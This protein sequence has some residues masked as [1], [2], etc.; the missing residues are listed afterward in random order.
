MRP[1]DQKTIAIEKI[2]FILTGPQRRDYSKPC[3]STWGSP[4]VSQEAEGE[5]GT[6]SKNIP[7]GFFKKEQR[8]QGKQA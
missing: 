3:R 6:M 2:V 5:R 4:R 1:T 7:C 8:R